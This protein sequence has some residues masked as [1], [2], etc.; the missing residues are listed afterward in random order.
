M[1]KKLLAL[2][3]TMIMCISLSAC[4]ASSSQTGESTAYANDSKGLKVVLGINDW[5]GSYW[6]LAVD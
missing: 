5:P 1:K 6:W 2:L 3:M 4:G